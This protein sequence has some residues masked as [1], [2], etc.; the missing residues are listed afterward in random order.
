MIYSTNDLRSKQFTFSKKV[1][2]SRLFDQCLKN[3]TRFW[4]PW[5]K[6]V[7]P[8]NKYALLSKNKP[9]TIQQRG[10]CQ[11]RPLKLSHFDLKVISGCC[12]TE[13]GKKMYKD[14]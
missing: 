1:K 4:F 6:A 9:W 7:L 11:L 13:D 14:L 5:A 10:A 12:F 2:N 8:R 3:V